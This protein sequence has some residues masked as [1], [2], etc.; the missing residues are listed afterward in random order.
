MATQNPDAKINVKINRPVRMSSFY[1]NEKFSDFRFIFIVGG[2]RS[3]IPAHKIVLVA[4]SAVFDA[5]FGG[6]WKGQHE[7]EVTDASFEAFLQFLQFIYLH[8]VQCSIKNISELVYLLDKYKI[9]GHAEN[10]VRQLSLD[11]ICIGLDVA[12]KLRLNEI[13]EH[14]LRKISENT[15]EVFASESFLHCSKDV[16]KAILEIGNINC[17]AVKVFDA[18]M[19]WAKRV[20]EE[21]AKDASIENLRSELGDCIY[22]IPFN[23]M[24]PQQVTQCVKKAKRFFN[25]DELEDLCSASTAYQSPLKLFQR[26]IF[27]SSDESTLIFQ[28]CDK[29]KPIFSHSTRLE[30]LSFQVNKLMLFGGFSIVRIF[31]PSNSKQCVFDA[32]WIIS[33]FKPREEI[34]AHAILLE[35][36]TPLIFDSTDNHYKVSFKKPIFLT[37]SITY[38]IRVEFE[39][40]ISYNSSNHLKKSLVGGNQVHIRDG[41]NLITQLYCNQ[42]N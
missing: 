24:K 30:K 22:A 18:C 33:E 40:E 10:L 19:A 37:P 42:V 15:S 34:Q 1:L 25:Q 7:V 29:Q 27:D 41:E 26:H 3:T 31:N 17:A 14:C 2:K 8:E 38:E 9:S 35:Q 13:K 4:A 11:K 36:S 12:L 20:C 5:L 39:G 28:L 16:L 23:S 6:E 21:K 32:D